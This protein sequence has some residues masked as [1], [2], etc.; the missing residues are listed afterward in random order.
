MPGFDN[1]GQQLQL[2]HGYSE[3]PG[4]GPTCIYDLMNAWFDVLVAIKHFLISLSQC[5]KEVVIKLSGHEQNH[6]IITKNNQLESA[7]KE[8]TSVSLFTYM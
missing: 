3:A 4:T 5:L 2:E 8:E 7:Y 6:F 1:C